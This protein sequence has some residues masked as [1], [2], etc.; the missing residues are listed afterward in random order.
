MWAQ[1]SNV[2]RNR[3]KQCDYGWYIWNK[4]THK[5]RIFML[6]WDIAIFEKYARNILY[7]PK[8]DQKY[9]ILYVYQ[10][11]DLLNVK[12]SGFRFSCHILTFTEQKIDEQY[13]AKGW[14]F[15][16]WALDL[17]VLHMHIWQKRNILVFGFSLLITLSRNSA[18]RRE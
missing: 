2:N 5:S 15:C 14:A 3:M 6:L 1:W 10:Y 12:I 9:R 16:S 8:S 11:F 7:P 13:G 4:K 18:T 17:Y